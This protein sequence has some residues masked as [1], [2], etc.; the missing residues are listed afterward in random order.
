MK[1]DNCLFVL[2][3]D[4]YFQVH[5]DSVE[6]HLKDLKKKYPNMDWRVDTHP[7]VFVASPTLK[8]YGGTEYRNPNEVLR[9]GDYVWITCVPVESTCSIDD[10]KVIIE[11]GVYNFYTNE[12]YGTRYLNR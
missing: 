2:T 4:M 12:D 9:Y 5:I 7:Y 8:K 11:P 6:S 3:D 1:N 10:D